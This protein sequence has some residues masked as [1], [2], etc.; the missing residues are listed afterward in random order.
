MT[1][2]PRGDVQGNQDEAAFIRFKFEPTGRATARPATSA[3]AYSR[4]QRSAGRGAERPRPSSAAEDV[5]KS[6]NG[7]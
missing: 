7:G 5:M 1:H 2:H 4:K 3:L 6:T